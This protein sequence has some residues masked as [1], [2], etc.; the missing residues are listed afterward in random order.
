[1]KNSFLFLMTLLVAC[2][3]KAQEFAQIS[4]GPSY[5]KQA[6]YTLADDGVT[7][8]ANEDWDLALFLDPGTHGIHFN[9][10]TTSTFGAPA[11]YLEVYL[12]PVA[13]FDVTIDPSELSD[14]L[15]NPESSWAEGAFNTV[16]DPNNPQ[17]VGWGIVN[18]SDG[19]V[20]GNR[21]YVIKLRD[22]SYRKL[23][24]DQQAGGVY[25]I[26]HAALDGSDEVLLNIDPADY[27]GSPLALY[28]FSGNQ[29]F[30][31]PSGWDMAFLRYRGLL[32]DGNQPLQYAVT[33]ILTAPGV[34][35][36][37]ADNVEVA[38]VPF[39][40]YEDSLQNRID[41]IGEDWKYFNLS[42]FSW[43]IAENR[44]YFLKLPDG[45]V[46]KLE[47]IDFEG[48]STGTATFIKYDLGVVTAVN[49]PESNFK[50]FGI[51]PNPISDGRVNL[52][53]SL[54]IPSDEVSI[55]VYDLSGRQVW[56]GAVA[57]HQGLNGV[58]LQLPKL[59]PGLYRV[60]LGKGTDQVS[61]L[62]MFN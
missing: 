57:T 5:G 61:E 44:A 28:T 31:A 33:G 10:A 37:Q 6:F 56:N 14:T 13:D 48:S 38:A 15:Y 32:Y 42:A 34:E 8:I 58:T 1:M 52:A 47:F 3:L 41:V 46:W 59:L 45:H 2:G 25:T 23:I 16:R 50:A 53:F 55:S 49:Q 62:V 36:A 30:A 24:F 22:E 21:V 39:E 40:A 7:S 17:D 26:R 18:P 27:T 4:T 60:V 19:S 11:P 12:A 9:E 35:V 20:A 29:A 54:K 51:F 43:E